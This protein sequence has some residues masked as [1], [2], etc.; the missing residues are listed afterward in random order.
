M[1][2]C[3]G[4]Q[5]E[6]TTAQAVEL[7]GILNAADRKVLDGRDD[8]GAKWPER[9]KALQSPGEATESALVPC[10]WP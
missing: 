5:A 1:A 10:M 8:D 9:L 7:T 4:K 6:K 2:K 3:F